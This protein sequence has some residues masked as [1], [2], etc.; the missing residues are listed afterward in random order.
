MK[1]LVHRFFLK[2]EVIRGVRPFRVPSE[3]AR[4]FLVRLARGC[5]REHFWILY[6]DGD[7]LCVGY[8]EVAMGDSEQVECHTMDLLRGAVIACA[9]SIVLVHNH[10]GSG[11]PSKEDRLHLAGLRR[12]A[13][14]V[15]ICVLGSYVVGDDGMHTIRETRRPKWQAAARR[16]RHRRSAG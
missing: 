3:Q 10:L 12:V 13:H 11:R 14:L 6:L 4:R 5:A 8:E 1:Q 7:D 2:R 15:G 16:R 9:T